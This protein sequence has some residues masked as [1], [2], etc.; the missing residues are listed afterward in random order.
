MIDA[1]ILSKVD[2]RV[3]CA[4]MCKLLAFT[5]VLSKE[6]GEGRKERRTSLG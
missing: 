3:C 2:M 5:C 1:C 6:G 4:D